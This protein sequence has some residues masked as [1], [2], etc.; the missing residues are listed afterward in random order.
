MSDY[1]DCFSGLL[2]VNILFTLNIKSI[3]FYVSKK[4]GMLRKI[5]KEN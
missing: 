5:K 2:L 3:I 4:E 1:N